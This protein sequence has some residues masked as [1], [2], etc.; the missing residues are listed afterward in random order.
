[1]G[2][3]DKKYNVGN[4]KGNTTRWFRYSKTNT[5][6]ISELP[7]TQNLRSLHIINPSEEKAI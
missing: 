3:S 6:A 1:M 4:G 5:M 7:G 2:K